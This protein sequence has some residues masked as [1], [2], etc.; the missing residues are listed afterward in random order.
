[1]LSAIILLAAAPASSIDLAAPVVEGD[2]IR[3]SDYP[4]RAV[5]EDKSA[6]IIAQMVFTPAGKMDACSILTSYGDPAL[7][8]QICRIIAKRRVKA[9]VIGGMPTF[10]VVRTL[11]RMFVP[12]TTD[13]DAIAK[14]SQAANLSLSVNR[15]PVGVSSPAR[16][17]VSL[18]VDA[19]GNASACNPKPGQETLSGLLTIACQQAMTL[20]P[21][22]V[23][24]SDG[25]TL[26]NYA[27]EQEVEFVKTP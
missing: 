27:I 19:Q 22:V 11:L 21:G 24:R 25:S 17:K 16:V 12:E 5:E 8:G 13:G 7:A 2:L 9:A 4:D 14:L 3:L 18:S 10:G 15:L 26:S 6:A 20:K 23:V 1:M